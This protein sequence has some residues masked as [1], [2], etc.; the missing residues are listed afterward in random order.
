M[1]SGFVSFLCWAIVLGLGFIIIPLFFVFSCRIAK[2]YHKA[3]GTR[4]TIWTVLLMTWTIWI[5]IALMIIARIW[6]QA[7]YI[8][9]KGLARGTRSVAFPGIIAVIMACL[10]SA[11]TYLA[12][13]AIVV[14]HLLKEVDLRVKWGN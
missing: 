4:A 9:V 7:Y 6:P 5:W 14:Y 1:F 3:L 2:I 10:S 13:T 12:P 8:T 11:V